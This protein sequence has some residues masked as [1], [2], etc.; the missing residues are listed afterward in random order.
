MGDPGKAR[1][2]LGWKPQVRFPALVKMM[3][4]ADIE[5]IR[6]TKATYPGRTHG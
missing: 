1:R 4:D 3:V 5:R 6:S 2:K